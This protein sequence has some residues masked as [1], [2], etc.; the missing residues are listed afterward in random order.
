MLSALPMLSK[1][2]PTSHSSPEPVG[3][4]W[5]L[6]ERKRVRRPSQYLP[7]FRGTGRVQSREENWTPPPQL[8]EQS[9]HD[10]QGPQPPACGTCRRTEC[11]SGI[12]ILSWAQ[13]QSPLPQA[14]C[15]TPALGSHIESL[16]LVHM[17]ATATHTSLCGPARG[18][19]GPG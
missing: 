10:P 18:T 2:F 8:R 7:P 19:I 13:G 15:P 14:L 1:G 17:E 3:Q 12:N 4:S 5:V 6:Q 11:K 16:E 9:P